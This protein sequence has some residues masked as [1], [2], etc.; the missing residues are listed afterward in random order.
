MVEGAVSDEELVRELS[1]IRNQLLL[2]MLALE[3]IQPEAVHHKPVLHMAA[4][5]C[6]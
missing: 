1:D 5:G 3:R 6:C 4:A 2:I